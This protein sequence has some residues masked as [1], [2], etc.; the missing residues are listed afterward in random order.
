MITNRIPK[1]ETLKITELAK[2]KLSIAEG[3]ITQIAL[4]C[5][6][7][8]NIMLNSNDGQN[9][10]IFTFKGESGYLRIYD[11]RAATY[12]FMLRASSMNE[13]FYEQ[14][15]EIFRQTPC[16][17]GLRIKIHKGYYTPY[18]ILCDLGTPDVH[19]GG[20]TDNLI[21]TVVGYYNKQTHRIVA[22]GNAQHK[23]TGICLIAPQKV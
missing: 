12:E 15:G 20:N 8:D 10:V 21:L 11:H 22:F 17:G 16:I 3:R 5:R 13:E 7:V 14:L 6:W 1:A 18:M 4:S 19:D 2:Q 9:N 23:P